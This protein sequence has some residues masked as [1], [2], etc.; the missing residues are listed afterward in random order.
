MPQIG[1]VLQVS[2]IG[3]QEYLV[4]SKFIYLLSYQKSWSHNLEF[5]KFKLNHI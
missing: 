3:S 4:W 2:I 1:I 5:L